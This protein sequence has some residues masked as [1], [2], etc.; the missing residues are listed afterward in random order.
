KDYINLSGGF[1][2]LGRLDSAAFYLEKSSRFLDEQGQY[3]TAREHILYRENLVN[4]LFATHQYNKA[5]EEHLNVLE[6]TRALSENKYA[7][8][9]AEMSAIY[10]LQAKEK[11][12]S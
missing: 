9:V 12:I 4:Y 10:E 7:Q 5:Y 11:S 3:L 8:A 1:I 6:A 2:Q